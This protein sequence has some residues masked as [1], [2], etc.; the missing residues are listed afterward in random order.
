MEEFVENFYSYNF[1]ED[2]IDK[3]EQNESGNENDDKD[4]RL[5]Y[6]SD[7]PVVVING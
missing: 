5:G 6:D 4:I 1:E 3:S 7:L 2:S